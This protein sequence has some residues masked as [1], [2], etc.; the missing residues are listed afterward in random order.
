[1]SETTEQID[2][3]KGFDENLTEAYGMCDAEFPII[4][5]ICDVTVTKKGIWNIVM[6]VLAVPFLGFVI[7]MDIFGDIFTGIFQV[8]GDALDGVPIAGTIFSLLETSEADDFIDFASMAI[9]FVFCG[10]VTLIGIPEYAEGLIELF[11]FWTGIIIFWLLI[12]RPARSRIMGKRGE[13]VQTQE[14][15]MAAEQGLPP[16]QKN[17]VQQVLGFL[18]GGLL[19]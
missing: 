18:T 19:K 16:P 12:I 5:S 11:P 8:L 3:K 15:K 1:M 10:P 9:V 4:G 17:I 6:I 2:I 13:A 14:V 7:F